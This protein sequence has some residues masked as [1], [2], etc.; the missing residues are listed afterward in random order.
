MNLT[1]FDIETLNL[2]IK[3]KGECYKI[4]STHFSDN[5][6]DKWQ[7]CNNCIL[8]K[9]RSFHNKSIACGNINEQDVF[10]SAIK[11]LFK[12]KLKFLAKNFLVST[13]LVIFVL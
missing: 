6:N 8:N 9:N 4:N 12:E 11:I 5:E 1:K 3:L 13:I 7:M 10:N 2:M